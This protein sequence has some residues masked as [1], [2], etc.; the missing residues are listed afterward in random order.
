MLTF[1]ILAA[2]GFLA[3]ALNSIAGGGSFLTFPALV[4][5]G[6]PSVLANATSAVSV[7]P[8][9][10]SSALG[11]VEELKKYGLKRLIG[12]VVIAVLGGVTGAMLLL[13]TSAALFEKVVPFLLLFATVLFACG[14]RLTDFLAKNGKSLN[15]NN[16]VLSFLVCSYGGYFNGGLGII[17]L[18]LF[19]AL[20]YRDLNLMNGLK[21]LLSFI[22]TAASILTFAVAGSVAWKWALWMMVFS[23]LG[24]Y[25]GAR[26]SRKIPRPV[27]RWIVVVIGL[28]MSVVFFIA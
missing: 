15:P 24:G 4:Y 5:A 18:A 8:G 21:S 26:W 1:L 3:G 10:L 12:L 14:S 17:L 22:L 20:G 9:Y 25:V 13:S 16:R 27:V 28:S 6:V 7:F 11:F 2:A 23:T 19:S